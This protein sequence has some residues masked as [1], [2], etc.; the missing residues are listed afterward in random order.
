MLAGVVRVICAPRLAKRPNGSGDSV[1]LAGVEMTSQISNDLS[2]V[3]RL[4]TLLENFIDHGGG[5]CEQNAIQIGTK[6]VNHGKDGRTDG[7]QIE[8]TSQISDDL[9]P[10]DGMMTS[11]ENLI[12][13]GDGNCEQNAVQTGTKKVNVHE[14]QVDVHEAQVNVHEA[15]VNVHE[16][17][18]NVHEAQVNVH[19]AQVDVHEAQVNVHEAQVSVHEAQVNV[20]EAQVENENVQVELL[21]ET[22]AFNAV[23]KAQ[24]TT[25]F[26][27]NVD[28]KQNLRRSGNQ[29]NTQLRGLVN[30]KVRKAKNRCFQGEENSHWH[31]FICNWQELVP[32]TPIWPLLPEIVITNSKEAPKVQVYLASNLQNNHENDRKNNGEKRFYCA[33]VLDE[34]WWN[35]MPVFPPTRA[36]PISPP[37][38]ATPL[39]CIKEAFNVKTDRRLGKRSKFHWK[40]PRGRLKI[41]DQNAHDY[42]NAYGHHNAHRYYEVHRYHNDRVDHAAKVNEDRGNEIQQ[43][44]A[45]LQIYNWIFQ[46]D[47]HG[48]EGDWE[49]PWPQHHGTNGNHGI[50]KALAVDREPKSQFPLGEGG[51]K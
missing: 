34:N 28:I 48:D 27:G 19:E 12:N 21:K 22:K 45:N 14:A 11:L 35:N 5:N 4:M 9:S 46:S 41:Q 30:I 3:T 50:R 15:Q 2:P 23:E 38:K 42:H 51:E 6:K 39:K 20:H 25:Q 18:V 13:R 44:L 32:R 17:Q 29:V 31:Y 16:A 7:G 43:K 40:R 1:V 10:L 8:M 33:A 24:K 47:H 26:D 36:T 49:E 37:T